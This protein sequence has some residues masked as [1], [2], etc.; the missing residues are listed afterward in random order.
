MTQTQ[1]HPDTEHEPQLLLIRDWEDYDDTGQKIEKSI[2]IWTLI[3]QNKSD[4][5]I[6]STVG[7]LYQRLKGL[8]HQAR[9]PVNCYVEYIYATSVME[10]PKVVP[11]AVILP[12]RE[13]MNFLES[14]D[15]ETD[16]AKRM[17][18]EDYREA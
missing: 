8:I 14:L 11:H 9:I 12:V 16:Q 10:N 5:L 7:P 6:K 15:T 18:A 1:N 4:I 13:V 2:P 17:Y 3:D